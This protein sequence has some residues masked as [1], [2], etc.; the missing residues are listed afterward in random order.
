MH[1]DFEARRMARRRFL[2]RNLGWIAPLALMAVVG[3]FFGIGNL[4]EWLWRVTVVDIFAFK[5]ISFWQAWGLILLSQILFKAN[6]RPTTRTG[7][8][9]HGGHA[10]GDSP[11]KEAQQPVSGN[12]EG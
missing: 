3:F 4:V 7:H 11:R 2:R 1:E 5:P 10:W 8:W 6:V 12:P 9:R